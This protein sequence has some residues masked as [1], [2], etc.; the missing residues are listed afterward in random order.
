VKWDKVGHGK[1]REKEGKGKAFVVDSWLACELGSRPCKCCSPWLDNTVVPRVLAAI[2]QGRLSWSG[3]NRPSA[4]SQSLCAMRECL[5]VT[6]GLCLGVPVQYCTHLLGQSGVAALAV[7]AV[8]SRKYENGMGWSAPRDR[9]LQTP[10][11]VRTSS[12]RCLPG[13][14]L[15]VSK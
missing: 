12:R 8:A 6:E 13:A 10:E 7:S 11:P 3:P 5:S 1:G 9:G 4:L 15:R 2:T 14:V